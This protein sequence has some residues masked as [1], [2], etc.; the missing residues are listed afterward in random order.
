MKK[1]GCV[2][3]FVPQTT[4]TSNIVGFAKIVSTISCISTYERNLISQTLLSHSG[5]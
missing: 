1:L 4:T 5:S 2:D 3:F